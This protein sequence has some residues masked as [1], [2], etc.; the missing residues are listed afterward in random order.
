[1]KS[2]ETCESIDDIRAE[3]DA[4]D[5]DI[6][7]LLGRRFGFAK[8]TVRFK[9]NPSEIVAQSRYDQVIAERRAMAIENGLNPDIVEKVYRTLMNHFIEEEMQL[10]RKKSGASSKG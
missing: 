3:I 9:S 2:P 6:M 4:L 7:R 10:L 8:A 1:M 5:R